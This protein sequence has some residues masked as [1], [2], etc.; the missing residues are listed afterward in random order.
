MGCLSQSTQHRSCGCAGVEQ[1]QGKLA[2][3]SGKG[4]AELGTDLSKISC[5]ALWG[6]GEKES[7]QL[8]SQQKNTPNT[9]NPGPGEQCPPS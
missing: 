5:S 3:G 2:A 6:Q 1:E 4:S 8:Q 9:A 7:S